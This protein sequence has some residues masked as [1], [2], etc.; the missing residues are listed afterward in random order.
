[1]AGTPEAQAR[2]RIDR[3]LEAAGWVVQDF[4]KIDLTAGHNGRANGTTY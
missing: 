1:M 3:Q 2:E 4:K